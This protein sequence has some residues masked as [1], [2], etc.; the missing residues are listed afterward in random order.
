MYHCLLQTRIHI[1]PLFSFCGIVPPAVRP[2]AKN[3]FPS[4]PIPKSFMIKSASLNL[5]L[6]PKNDLMII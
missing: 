6:P 1:H 2:T 4:F 3:G 5:F